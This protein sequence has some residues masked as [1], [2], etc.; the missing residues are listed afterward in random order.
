MKKTIVWLVLLALLLSLSVSAAGGAQLGDVNQDG[1][2]T[3]A[4]VV[5][6]ARYVINDVTFTS[7]QV[8]LADVT[9]DDKINSADVI[10]LARYIVGLAALG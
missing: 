10:R 7:A 5:L 8:G 2:I 9:G 6:I 1:R 3:A 4:D